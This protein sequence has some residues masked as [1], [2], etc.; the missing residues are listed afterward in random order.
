[1]SYYTIQSGEIYIAQNKE[2]LTK[3][4]DNV[5]PLPEDYEVGKY[6]I[7][8]NELILNPDYEA[9][10]EQKEKERIAKLSLTRG[11]V[12]RAL[13]QAKQIT[14]TQIRALI[15]NNELISEAQRELALIDFDEALNF[16]RGNSLIDVIGGALGITT[17]QMDKFFMDGN[18]ENL[19]V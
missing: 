4:Y 12:F 15:E 10:Q 1:M 14:R 11:D 6:I 13:Y 3:Y 5:K 8:N 16:Y 9:E 17:K 19:L 18:Y 2:A 7:E